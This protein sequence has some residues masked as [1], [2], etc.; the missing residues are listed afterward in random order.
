VTEV[1]WCKLPVGIFEEGYM[2]ILDQMPDADALQGIWMKL[3]CLAGKCNANGWVW[4]AEGQPYTEE[5]LASIMRRPLNTVRLALDTLINLGKIE[6]T[7][8]G[9]FIPDFA[10][11]NNL[12]KLE[13]MRQQSKERMAR[14][15][16]RLK[17]GGDDQDEDCYAN[18]TQQNRKEKIRKDKD[19]NPLQGAEAPGQKQLETVEYGIETYEAACAGPG[20][21]VGMLVQ[22]FR[23]FHA[24]AP[25]EDLESCG[26]RIADW[27]KRKSRD[28]RYI[29]RAI[30]DTA[31]IRIEGSHLNYIHGML[32]PKQAR[33]QPEDPDRY[34]KGTYGHMVRR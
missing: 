34:V 30:W 1:T 8:E 19:T 24:G 2:A 5:T 7:E 27:W 6:M 23:Q 13:R 32:F 12:E 10:A 11:W 17:Q 25:A 26:G 14:Y 22:A 9:I 3:W 29:L 15:R 20:N 33:P 21:K 4:Y 31:A 18:V 28:T 16:R